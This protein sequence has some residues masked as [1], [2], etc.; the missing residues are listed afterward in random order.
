MVSHLVEHVLVHQGSV[1]QSSRPETSITAVRLRLLLGNTDAWRERM[2]YT[3]DI[4][5][6][7]IEIRELSLARALSTCQTAQLRTVTSVAR[8]TRIGK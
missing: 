1:L 4:L 6:A 7:C 2:V 3:L 5:G 8:F